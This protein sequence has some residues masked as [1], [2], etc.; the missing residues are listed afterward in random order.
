MRTRTFLLAALL[1]TGVLAISAA[2]S[3]AGRLSLDDQ[4]FRIVWTN[5]SFITDVVPPE[6]QPLTVECPVTL[7]GSFHGATTTKTLNRL[8]GSVTSATVGDA[9]CTGGR[10]SF[11]AGT[12]PWHVLYVSFSGTLPRMTGVRLALSAPGFRITNGLFE[13]IG[14]TDCLWRV[15]PGEGT[16]D[17]AISNGAASEAHPDGATFIDGSDTAGALCDTY[18]IGVALEGSGVL[19]DGASNALGVSLI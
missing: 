6:E 17:I 10:A 1:A 2:G 18:D 9:S 4:D 8:L 5:L 15:G 12:L 19:E 14:L 11:L 3:A 16:L 7:A 13:L